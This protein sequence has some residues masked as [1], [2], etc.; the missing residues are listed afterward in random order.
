MIPRE[1]FLVHGVE[2]PFMAAI[3]QGEGK[4]EKEGSNNQRL[5]PTTGCDISRPDLGRYHYIMVL[6]GRKNRVAIPSLT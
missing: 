5:S 6:D 2:Q 3:S 1:S 4:E